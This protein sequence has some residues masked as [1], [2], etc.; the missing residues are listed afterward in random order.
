ML[1]RLF[2]VS[3]FLVLQMAFTTFAEQPQVLVTGRTPAFTGDG[4]Q[5][6]CTVTDED[7]DSKLCLVPLKKP[8]SA[9]VLDVAGTSPVGAPGL[10]YVLFLG[11]GIFPE[12]F[13]LDIKTG[14]A[15]KLELEDFPSGRP[16]LLNRERQLWA[17]PVGY[18]TPPKMAIVDMVAKR[19]VDDTSWKLP[20]E[21]L[22]LSL[23]KRFAAVMRHTGGTSNFAVLDLSTCEKPK[24]IFET[25]AENQSMQIGGCHSPVFSPDGKWLAYVTADIQPIA[26]IVLL[27]LKTRRRVNL[28]NDHADNQSPVFS[29][30]G[31]KIAFSSCRNG[32]YQV[33]VM[34][35]PETEAE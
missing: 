9:R 20:E 32:K 28:T 2:I 8:E 33:F 25:K 13:R 21:T 14:T 1:R 5:I 23:D 26:D 34:P 11:E 16:F 29:P 22:A 24:V 12:L 18:D 4:K 15:E 31:K 7:G 17:F 35:V 19:K 10:Q 3:V 6:V 27:N 30:D